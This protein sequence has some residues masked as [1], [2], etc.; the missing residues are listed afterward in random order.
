M[1][2]SGSPVS[3]KPSAWRKVRGIGRMKR[4]HLLPSFEQGNTAIHEVTDTSQAFYFERL[5]RRHEDRCV[6]SAHTLV[7]NVEDCNLEVKDR[8][9]TAIQNAVH[10]SARGC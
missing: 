6:E 5:L 1:S 7:N 9:P 8:N 4:K 10:L 2:L 3:I